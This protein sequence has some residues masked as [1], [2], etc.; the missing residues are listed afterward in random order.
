MTRPRPVVNTQLEEPRHFIWDAKSISMENLGALSTGSLSQYSALLF[1]EV[2]RLGSD[3]K[4][5]G[6]DARIAEL[7]VQISMYEEESKRREAIE[8]DIKPGHDKI[9]AARDSYII[10]DMRCEIESVT[11]FGPGTQLPVFIASLTNT[12][13]SFVADEPQ[14]EPH[15]VRMAISRLDANYATRVHSANPKIQSF[16]ALKKHLEEHHG[17]K[18]T[19]FQLM[20]EFFDAPVTSELDDYAVLLEN[21]TIR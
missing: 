19:C 16:E 10:R 15:F 13:K 9:G 21:T 11:K 1:T 3:N 7:Q 18:A 12:F 2:L 5:K 14:Y 6:H 17:S 20:D 4:D 8:K